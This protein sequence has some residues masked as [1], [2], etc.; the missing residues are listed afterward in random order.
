MPK[1]LLDIQDVTGSPIAG[2]TV[3]LEAPAPRPAAGGKVTRPYRHIVDLDDAGRAEVTVESG[4]L[5]VMF[6]DTLGRETVVDTRVPA[7]G[8]EFTLGALITTPDDLVD[9]PVTVAELLALKTGPQGERGPQ[10]EQGEPGP[11]GPAGAKGAKGDTG[12]QGERGPAGPQ[13]EQGERGPQGPQ[14]EQGEPG[15][16]GP[17]GAKG[18]KGD[19]GA[20]GE[21]GPAGPQG[22]QGER[23]PQ[24]EPG[25][26]S[27]DG[28]TNKPDN[29]ARVQVVNALPSS[30]ARNTLYLI[31]E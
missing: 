12:A 23:G 4:P 31:P 13:G 29:L 2:D 20:Q 21:R 28:I 15:P 14:G 26:T 11:K 22:E 25:T 7:D 16:K 18:A 27:W 24:G 8:D 3:T 10:G 19:T 17:A 9:D 5:R 30:P 6:H 1:L